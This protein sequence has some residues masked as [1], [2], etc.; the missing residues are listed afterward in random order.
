MLKFGAEEA[1]IISP[2][3]GKEIC[4]VILDDAAEGCVLTDSEGWQ[5]A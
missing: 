1:C 4:G 3:T 2:V 5:C